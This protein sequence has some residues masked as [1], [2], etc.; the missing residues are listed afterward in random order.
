MTKQQ[1]VDFIN[2]TTKKYKN[3]NEFILK[4]SEFYGEKFNAV[5]DAVEQLML[6]GKIIEEPAGKFKLTENTSYIKGKLIGHNKGFAFVD[7]G[8]PS[9][10]DFFIPPTK[11]NGAFNGDTVLIRPLNKTDLSQEAEVVKILERNNTTIVGTYSRLK[12]G[13]GIV[14]PDNNKF[15]KQILVSRKASMGAVGGQ[16]VVVKVNFGKDNTLNGEVIE[17]L[18]DE[19]DFKTLELACI[20]DHKLY[21]EF[22]DEVLA[23]ANKVPQ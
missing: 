21:E 23:E 2:D 18:G 11:L 3:R 6:E 4:I 20:R 13:D 14:T 1:V 15:N 19:A 16:K 8:D 22:P 10:P 7:V 9:V 12:R 17:I 5:K